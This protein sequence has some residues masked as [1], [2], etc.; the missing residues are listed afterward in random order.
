MVNAVGEPYR[1]WIVFFFTMAYSIMGHLFLYFFEAKKKQL[2]S[3]IHE[4]PS[5]L[6]DVN[7]AT[8]SLMLRGI[9]KWIPRQEVEETLEKLFKKILGKSLVKTNVIWDFPKLN[10]MLLYMKDH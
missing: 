2:K 10:K 5:K 9:R 6:T 7:I 3:H 8:H 1:V 4:D